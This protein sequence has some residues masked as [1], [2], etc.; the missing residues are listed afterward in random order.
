MEFKNRLKQLRTE[1]GLSQKQ[2]A[3]MVGAHVMNIS[4]YERGEN[5]PTSE[6]LSKLANA[7]DTSV[8]YLM[9]GS[10]DDRAKALITD[11]E[12]LS[13]FKRIEDLPDNKKSVIK[14]LIDAFLFKQ[15]I[16][17]KLAS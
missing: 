15:D 8:D 16:Q 1:K 4:R 13:Q 14:E 2:L 9:S 3:E 12:L 17:Q 5:R 7:L 10:T 6:V 11:K